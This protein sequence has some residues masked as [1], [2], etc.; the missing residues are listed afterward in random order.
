MLLLP[1]PLV[2]GAGEDVLLLPEPVF[3]GAGE[4]VPLL[5]EPAVIAEESLP[6]GAPGRGGVRMRSMGGPDCA[7]SL[8]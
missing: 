4:N 3:V 6:L 1:E 2:V 5:T 8:T 7:L